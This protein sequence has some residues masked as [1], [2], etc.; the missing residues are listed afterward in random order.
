MTPTRE[1]NEDEIQ[2]DET[3]N[4]DQRQGG[5]IKWSKEL[6]YT[7]TSSPL[8]SPQ[9]SQNEVDGRKRC[10]RGLESDSSQTNKSVRSKP[11]KRGGG[12]RAMWDKID[13]M[14][15]LIVDSRK[16]SKEVHAKIMNFMTINTPKH[17]MADGCAKLCSLTGLE[18]GYPLF[19]FVC[20]MM[21]DTQKRS[22]FFEMPDDQKAGYIKLLY[23]VRNNKNLSEAR[24]DNDMQIKLFLLMQNYLY[25]END[26]RN[27]V[28]FAAIQ[29]TMGIS[30]SGC[31]FWCC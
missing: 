7:P 4:I 19:Y 24:V 6:I 12:A 1:R 29:M 17:S 18:Y 13:A 14:M 25:H 10:K 9:A 30:S 3:E 27:M 21:E 26:F 11:S 22:I 15:Q 28:G 2:E 8:P 31:W 23:E 5:R 20:T 16:E